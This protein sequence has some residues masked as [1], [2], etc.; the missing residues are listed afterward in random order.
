MLAAFA[1]EVYFFLSK[2][3]FHGTRNIIGQIANNMVFKQKLYFENNDLKSNIEQ[4]KINGLKEKKELFYAIEAIRHFFAK[5]G[6]SQNAQIEIGYSA[7]I[8]NIGKYYKSFDT[9]LY[10]VIIINIYF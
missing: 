10:F 4:N 1:F 3:K 9:L 6:I 2:K 8:E 7:I 5:L